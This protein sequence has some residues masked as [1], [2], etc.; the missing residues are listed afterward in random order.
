MTDGE[1]YLAGSCEVLTAES[2]EAGG[3][4]AKSFAPPLREPCLV[5]R[6]K[7]AEKNAPGLA[8]GLGLWSVKLPARVCVKPGDRIRWKGATLTVES[9]NSLNDRRCLTVAV[10]RGGEVEQA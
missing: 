6:L 5:C 3:V 2:G 1:R 9:A 8:G 10:C 7:G 4:P